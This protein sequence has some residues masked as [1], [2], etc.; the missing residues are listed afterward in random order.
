ML[1]ET[2]RI[3]EV[4]PHKPVVDIFYKASIKEAIA[5]LQQHRLHGSLTLAFFFQLIKQPS[6]STVKKDTGS[7]RARFLTLARGISST[8]A[9]SALSISSFISSTIQTASQMP[10]FSM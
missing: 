9:S 10:A 2:H 5:L 4:L 3:L 1:L 7:G 8:L 6:P